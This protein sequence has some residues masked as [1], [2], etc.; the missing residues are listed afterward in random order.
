MSD[1]TT[2]I[3]EAHGAEKSVISMM[4]KNPECIAKAQA[5][6]LTREHFHKPAHA[7]IFAAIVSAGQY[8]LVGFCEDAHRSGTLE[9]MGGAAGVAD[10]YTYAPSAAHW[11]DHVQRLRNAHARR[12]ILSAGQAIS[13][14]VGHAELD[15]LQKMLTAASEKAADALRGRSRMMEA[16]EAVEAL[17]KRMW[18]ITQGDTL[19]AGWKTGMEPIDAVTG[20]ARPGQLWVIAGGTSSGKSVAMIQAANSVADAGGRVLIVSLEMEAWEV[21]ARIASC[22]GWV[23]FATFMAPKKSNKFELGKAK[24]SLAAIEGYK[25]AIDDQGGRSVAQIDAMAIEFASKH[26]SIDLIVVDYIQLI[27]SPRKGK[28]DTR[29]SEIAAVSRGLKAMAKKFQCPVLT[30]SQLNDNGRLRESRAI[31]H[32]ADVV[33]CIEEEGIRAAKIRNAPRGQLF[34]L[35]LNGDKQRFEQR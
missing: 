6:G 11:D 13:E 5:E 33:L 4:M 16:K 35:V 2:T 30:G 21:M 28:S 18:A 10:I 15:D 25:L 34:P 32:D 12:L 20:G 19:A 9:D 14:E 26:G 8:E 17:K 24:D 22:R 7:A 31:G 29:E 1:E 3:P 23:S 27:D